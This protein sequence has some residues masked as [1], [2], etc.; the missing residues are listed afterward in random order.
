MKC[1]NWSALA[2]LLVVCSSAAYAKSFLGD[3]SNID[4]QPSVVSQNL[5]QQIVTQTF[6]DSTG[7]IWFVTQEGLNRYNG[8]QLENY[9]YS[10]TNPQSLSHDAVTSITED[11]TGDVWVSTRGGGLN[12]YDRI[13]NGF[14]SL[15][16]GESQDQSPIFSQFL[17]TATERFGSDMTT[18]SAV[19]T[20]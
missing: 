4:F 12:K 11:Q 17:Q 2:L 8:T 3:Q 13:S 6:Q 9:R 18:P 14:S 20:P 1:R 19:S 15:L 10:L 5:T 7:N 16:A